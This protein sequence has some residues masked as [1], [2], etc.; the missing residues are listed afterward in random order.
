MPTKADIARD[1]GTTPQY[2]A[3]KVKEGCPTDSLENARL[4]RQAHA[5]SKGDSQKFSL[6]RLVDE[7]EDDSPEAR[8][9]RKKY[10]EEHPAI[11]KDLSIEDALLQARNTAAEAYRLLQEAMLTDLPSQIA[12][13]LNIHNK[14]LEALWKSE[15]CYREELERRGI[16]IEVSAANE[17]SRRAWQ[18]VVSRLSA[19]PQN[20]APR[21]NPHDPNHA[22]ELLQKECTSIVA[23]VRKVFTPGAA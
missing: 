2:V 1:W 23:D 13:L 17:L 4:W 14:A 8:E 9:R 11:P 16:L 12:P 15:Q 10:L 18:I 21:C 6:R 19:L 22:M 20:M 3:A 7:H 5:M